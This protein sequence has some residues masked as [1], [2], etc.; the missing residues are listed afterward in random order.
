MGNPIGDVPYRTD[1]RGLTRLYCC[2]ILSTADRIVGPQLRDRQMT[3]STSLVESP[4]PQVNQPMKSRLKTS[5]RRLDSSRRRLEII[6]RFLPL[7]TTWQITHRHLVC[8]QPFDWLTN[9]WLS[10]SLLVSLVNYAYSNLDVTMPR[11]FGCLI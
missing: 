8:S 3:A 2:S 5:K 6:F 1:T 4:N 11:P 10:H 7:P 9:I